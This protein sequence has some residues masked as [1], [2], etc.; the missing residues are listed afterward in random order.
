[1]TTTR[2]VPQ[3]VLD[4]QAARDLL[5]ERGWN[6]GHYSHHGTYCVVGA[7]RKVTHHREE[8]PQVLEAVYALADSLKL[9][10]CHC[11][12]CCPLMVNTVISWNDDENRSFSEVLKALDDAIAMKLGVPKLMEVK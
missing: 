2:Q 4:L 10:K 8:H 1:M 11:D 9:N 7:L 12:I 6:Q 5:V 3:V